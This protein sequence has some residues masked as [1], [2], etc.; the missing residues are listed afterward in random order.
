MEITFRIDP[1]NLRGYADEFLAFAWH[2]A[3][4]N[5]APSGDWEAADLVKR[6]GWE[7]I[8]RW[9]SKVE[10]EIHHHQADANYHRWMTAFAKYEPPAGW[11]RRID[12][13]GER[14]FHK[15]R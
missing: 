5:P 3:Q 7:I 10:P 1:D 2:A 13:E 4:H 15:G 6:V 9:L 8:R 14:E 11:N 12:R